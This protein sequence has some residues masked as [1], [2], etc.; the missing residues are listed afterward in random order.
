[1]HQRQQ[2]ARNLECCSRRMNRV[3]FRVFCC[4]DPEGLHQSRREDTGGGATQDP[5]LCTACAQGRSPRIA[6]TSG[7]HS[8]EAS[9]PLTRR[10]TITGARASR[11]LARR[12]NTSV[13]RFRRAGCRLWRE[14]TAS[15][16]IEISDYQDSRKSGR[17]NDPR[18]EP[19]AP[20]NLVAW[21]REL[22]VSNMLRLPRGVSS[23]L[24]RP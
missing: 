14:Q 7:S 2:G 13:R 6:A 1:M 4:I 16:K 20:C 17:S 10:G 12:Q 11:D 22:G 15:W 19:R 8:I 3:M 9:S 5:G 21:G 24:T 18:F 23:F